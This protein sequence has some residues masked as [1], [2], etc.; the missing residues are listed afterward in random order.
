MNKSKQSESIESLQ[1]LKQQNQWLCL[2]TKKL[3]F[4]TYVDIHETSVGHLLIYY[5]IFIFKYL[6]F[7]FLCFMPS[8]PFNNTQDF[9]SYCFNNNICKKKPL[10]SF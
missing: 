6:F 7:I 5:F 3:I 4:N 1:K 9:V 10:N 8:I 2:V